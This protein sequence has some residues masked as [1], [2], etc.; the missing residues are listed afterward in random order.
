MYGRIEGRGKEGLGTV[1]TVD[2]NPN[3][4]L[5]GAVTYL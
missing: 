2:T 1:S 3:Y 5:I 4:S